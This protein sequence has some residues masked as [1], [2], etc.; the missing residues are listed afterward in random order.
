MNRTKLVRWIALSI[1]VLLAAA[2]ITATWL[3]AAPSEIT[4]AELASLIQ[5]KEITNG[6]VQPTLYAGIYHIEGTRKSGGQSESFSITTH[7]DGDQA[8]SLFEQNGVT[9]E[10]PGQN[11][12][13][14]WANILSTLV[15]CVLVV[16]LVIFQTTSRASRK[17]RVRSGKSWTF[18]ATQKN[19]NVSAARCPK[20]CC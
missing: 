12:R 14:Q 13:G 11:L 4:R 3:K 5:K 16:A 6:K 17:P 1:V 9:V 20:A 19:I 15:V 7:L 18:C 2:G 8:K 10:M